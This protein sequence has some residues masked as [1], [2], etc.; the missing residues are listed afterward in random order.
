MRT[1]R[2]RTGARIDYPLA[3]GHPRLQGEV[4][5]DRHGGNLLPR[6]PR[7]LD[8]CRGGV[9]GTRRSHPNG[10]ADGISHVRRRQLGMVGARLKG[11]NGYPQCFVET[12]RHHH[13]QLV[14]PRQRQYTCH[15]PQRLLIA[16]FAGAGTDKA[17]N[18]CRLLPL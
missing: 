17:A 13:H 11:L 8:Q 15:V 9:E 18:S 5:Q 14:L 3:G 10:I 1:D 7:G 2:D 12:Q 16:D 4:L 6:V